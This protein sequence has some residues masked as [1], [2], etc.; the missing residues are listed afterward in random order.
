MVIDLKIKKVFM[1]QAA[2][3]D[4]AEARKILGDMYKNMSMEVQDYYVRSHVG[5]LCTFCMCTLAHYVHSVCDMI[6]RA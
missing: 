3:Q 4:M 1:M 6:V 5:Q 2:D